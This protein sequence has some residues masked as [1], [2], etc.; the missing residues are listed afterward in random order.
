M[1]QFGRI[2]VCGAVSIYNMTD[3]PLGKNSTIHFQI[4][5]YLHNCISFIAPVVQPA[6]VAFQLRME[7]FVYSRFYDKWLDGIF[8]MKKW[9]KEGKIKYRETITYGFENMVEAFVDMLQG[10]NYGK[11]VVKVQEQSAL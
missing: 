5:T 1:N 11:A 10:G 8:Q 7:G 4:H 3:E 6:M 9:I 2:S